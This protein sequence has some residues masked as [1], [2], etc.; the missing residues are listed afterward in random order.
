MCVN[1]E[2]LLVVDQCA[3]NENKNIPPASIATGTGWEV[4]S[5]LSVPSDLLK[6]VTRERKYVIERIQ[7][8]SKDITVTRER[9]REVLI[10]AKKDLERIGNV[11]R[12]ALQMARCRVGYIID[13]LVSSHMYDEEKKRRNNGMDGDMPSRSMDSLTYVDVLVQDYV[14]R[15]G[16]TG[17][18]S[19][20]EKKGTEVEGCGSSSDLIDGMLYT[21]LS[22]LVESLEKKRDC[23]KALEWCKT[24]RV[25]LKKMQSSLMF[26][27]HVQEF[28]QILRAGGDSKENKNKAIT[29]AKTYLSPYATTYPDEFQRA[30]SL[31]VLRDILPESST[32][33]ELFGED[34][35]QSLVS[36]LRHEFF[37]L[38]GVALSSPLET[39]LKAGISA[40][41]TP[42]SMNDEYTKDVGRKSTSSSRDNPL[43]HPLVHKMAMSLPCAK[44]TVS[45]LVCPVTGM[46]MEGTNAPMVLPNGYVYGNL[47]LQGGFLEC[48]NEAHMADASQLVQCPC[49]GETFPRSDV[50]R[51]YI[52]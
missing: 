15:C 45:K 37:T 52:V 10:A 31:V 22:Q 6:R 46:I 1:V 43:R 48:R 26:H 41:K 36:Q 38:H 40:L 18:L 14:A 20:L 39:Y 25:K 16:Y 35:W 51:A 30:A 47:A 12:Q 33:S 21:E 49:T 23:G 28:V 50:R 2:K 11:E 17:T 7:K 32:C 42:E 24:H 13:Q 5:H 19:C 8:Y 9:M 3:M 29:Y 27:L 44:R 4:S 34:R